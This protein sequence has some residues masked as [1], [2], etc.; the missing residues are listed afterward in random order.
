MNID[1][2]NN[3]QNSSGEGQDIISYLPDFIIGQILS[4]LPTKQAVRTCVLSTRWIYRWRSITKVDFQ[5]KDPSSNNRITKPAFQ[6][7]V[8]RVLHL[9]TS[10]IQSFSLSLSESH[11]DM[12][13]SKWISHVLNRGVREIYIDSKEKFD[14]SSESLLKTPSLEVLVLKMMNYGAIKVPTF[15]SLSHLTVLQLSGIIFTYDSSKCSPKLN[16]NF[17][18]LRKYE[19]ENCT[20]LNI[21]GVTFEVPLL[22]VLS[23]KHTR[24]FITDETLTLIKFCTSHL[25]EFS[26]VGY[27]LQHSLLLHLS[28]IASANIHLI[29]GEN[30]KNTAFLTCELLNQLSNKVERLTYKRSAQYWSAVSKSVPYNA[31]PN[32]VHALT[33]HLEFG[34]LTRLELGEVTGKVLMDFLLN[35]PSLKTLV[36]EVLCQFEEELPNYDKVPSCF[37][38]NLQLVNFG[39]YEGKYHELRFVQ[40]VMENAQ[41][42]KRA[43]FTVGSNRHANIEI[44]LSFKRRFIEFS[45]Y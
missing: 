34:R 42:L 20:W 31:Y 5:D 8:H 27:S 40:F 9:N 13:V 26:Y 12:R 3:R 15:A 29:K 36:F 22:Q 44:I 17:P 35:T 19:V 30:E 37:I 45:F 4:F 39:R 28:T 41:V 7:F 6:N 2:I 10:G 25:K 38:S 1:S 23:I 16:F 32:R 43:I 24:E 21:K 18:T 33:D 11:A 14:I